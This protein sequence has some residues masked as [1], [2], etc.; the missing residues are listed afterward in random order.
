VH[1]NPIANAP[2][3]APFGRQT[4]GGWFTA[5]KYATCEL[6]VELPKT[7]KLR[8]RCYAVQEVKRILAHTK[9]AIRV[10]FWLAAAAV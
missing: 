8:T 4:V 10:F 2:A 9:S 7:R 1:P 6:R 3:K 5:W